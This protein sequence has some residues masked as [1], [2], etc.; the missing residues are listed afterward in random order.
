MAAGDPAAEGGGSRGGAAAGAAQRNGAPAPGAA[1]RAGGVAKAALQEAR[2]QNALQAGAG[3]APAAR[4]AGDNAELGKGGPLVAQQQQAQ[5]QL[6]QQQQQRQQQSARFI[7]AALDQV[8]TDERQV[9]SSALGELTSSGPPETHIVDS[10]AEYGG[11]SSG[12]EVD[13]DASACRL[14]SACRAACACPGKEAAPAV[15]QVREAF[16]KLQPRELVDAVDRAGNTGLHLA[17]RAGRIELFRA[18]YAQSPAMLGAENLDGLS[19]LDLAAHSGCLALV[20]LAHELDREAV[21]QEHRARDYFGCTTC[22]QLLAG[23]GRFQLTSCDKG[24]EHRWASGAEPPRHIVTLRAP[25]FA[26]AVAVS[27]SELGRAAPRRGWWC[28][29]VPEQLAPSN[30]LAK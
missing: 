21:E 26:A 11:H 10:W 8:D 2:A 6:Q 17:A 13:V 14:L 16:L 9:E 18:L 1:A 3:A 27:K 30:T 29:P 20:L 12:D 5:Q 24:R 19:P 23:R 28:K 7:P 22:G 4:G 15:S 25:D